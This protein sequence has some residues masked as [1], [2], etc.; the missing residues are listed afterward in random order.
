MSTEEV[1]VYAAPTVGYDC[2]ELKGFRLDHTWLSTESGPHNWNCYGRGR[3]NNH[4]AN[5]RRIGVAHG[6]VAWMAA[7]Y[8][9]K[10]EG[11]SGRGD[12]DPAAAGVVELLHGVCQNAANRILAMTEENLDVSKAAGNELV[13]LA[14]GKYGFGVDR[15]IER[16]KVTAAD[17]NAKVPGSVTEEELRRTIANVKAG[18]TVNAEFYALT[19]DLPSIRDA[20]KVSATD[21]Q[22]IEF[23]EK[24]V[25]FQSRRAEKF[26]AIEKLHLPNHDARGQMASFLKVELSNLLEYMRGNLGE[27]VYTQ[28]VSVV[29][30]GAW[31]ML[32]KIR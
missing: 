8:G 21:R 22:R 1:E 9:P 26:A 29:P 28:V 20:F 3:S 10:A 4:D 19:D 13:V 18:T 12:N 16:L 15:F 7:V 24:Y 17:L 32:A 14:F 27:D 2:N 5:T 23:A 11:R 25:A 31:D 30:N 6:N